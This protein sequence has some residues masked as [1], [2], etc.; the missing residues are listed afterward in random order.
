[1]VL[2]HRVE[3]VGGIAW[4]V[5]PDRGEGVV[6]DAAEQQRVGG[7]GLFELEGLA[8]GAAG[9]VIRPA[10][11]LERFGAARRFDDAVDGDVFGDH[12]PAHRNLPSLSSNQS[13]IRRLAPAKIIGRGRESS[14]GTSTTLATCRRS[15][16][17]VCAAAA[18]S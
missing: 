6:S 12:D 7:R 3:H 5:R 17:S 13:F 14:Y 4:H 16:I 10:D 11:A 18:P 2:W 15:S 9:K 1:D 8:L